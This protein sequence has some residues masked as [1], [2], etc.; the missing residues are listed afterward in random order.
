MTAALDSLGSLSARRFAAITGGP[1]LCSRAVRG[2]KVA[3]S[4]TDG[5]LGVITGRPIPYNSLSGDLGGFRELYSPGC[6]SRSL[7][8]DS[9]IAALLEHRPELILGKKSAGTLTLTEG[10][11]GVHAEIEVGDTS[12][13]RDLLT[14]MGRKDVDGMSAA[15]FIQDRKWEMR[16]G[17]RVR[18]ITQAALVEVSVCAFPAYADAKAS[19]EDGVAD[20]TAAAIA[21]RVRDLPARMLL[22]LALGERPDDGERAVRKLAG[23]E[24]DRLVKLQ[25]LMGGYDVD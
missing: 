11:D 1:V 13:G 21:A 12:Y 17:Q 18:V 2:T 24:V 16:G 22:S 3:A 10:P 5:S 15:F 8:S 23:G 19:S 14:S 20:N 25:F 4:K 7:A 6:F 9:P